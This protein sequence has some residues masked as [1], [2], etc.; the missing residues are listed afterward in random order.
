MED[1]FTS[2]WLGSAK[3]DKEELM[4]YKDTSGNPIFSSTEAEAFE[5]YSEIN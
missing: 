5:L 3:F 2:D 4:K 1:S